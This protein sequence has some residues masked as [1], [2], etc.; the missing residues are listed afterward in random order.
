MVKSSPW[1][2]LISDWLHTKLLL[3]P[4]WY[5]LLVG[6]VEP[7]GMS[8]LQSVQRNEHSLVSSLTQH[9]LR[10]IDHI[11]DTCKLKT[12][13]TLNSHTGQDIHAHRQMDGWKDRQ[14]DR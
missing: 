9:D 6:S 12:V 2:G 7:H 3:T 4:Q 14:I 11:P 8:S 1:L 5:G 13:H 10:V